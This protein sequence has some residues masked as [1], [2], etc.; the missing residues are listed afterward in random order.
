MFFELGR[1]AC[2]NF[3]QAISHEWLVTNGIGG[4]ACGTVAE[5]NTRRYHGLLMA[6]LSPPTGRVL[7]VSKLDVAACYLKRRYDLFS[8]VFAD[9]T[10]APKGFTLLESFRLDQG[11]PVW[12]YAIADALI[13]KRVVMQPGSNTTLATI[14]ILRAS[15]GIS[16]DL[17]P[18]CAY[19][20]YHGLEQGELAPAIH[21]I[22]GGFEV[23]AFPGAKVYR[24]VCDRG[25][26]IPGFFWYRYFKYRQETQRGLDDTE[27]LFRPG[28]FHLTLAEGEKATVLLTGDVSAAEDYDRVARQIQSKRQH[29]LQALPDDVPEWIEQLALAAEQF[30]VD[31][32]S[33]RD[34]A[35]K[36]VIAG[37][38]WFTDWGRDTMIALPGL[39]L[40]LGHFAIAAD[41][42]RTFAGYVSAGMIPNRFPD[43]G[44]DPEYNTVDAT[45]WFIHALDRYT[46]ESGDAALAAELFPVLVDII[47]W[48]RRGSRYGIRVDS[49]DGLLTAGETGMQLTWMDA[50]VDDWVVTPRSGKCVEINALW[51]NALSVMEGLAAQVGREDLAEDYRHSAQR[52]KS[53]FRRFWNADRQCLYDVIHGE[54]GELHG[55]GRLYDGRLRPNQL[56]AV[57]LPHSPLSEAQQ[58]AVVD[59]CARELLTSYGLRSLA[60]SD[61]GYVLQYQ[62]DRKMRDGAYHQGTVWAWLIG[63]FVD[64]HYRVYRDRE[65]ALSFLEPFRQH[66]NEGC[67]GQIAEI[68]DAIPPFLPRGC[69]AQ[70][71]SVAEVL[72][73]WLTLAR[74]DRT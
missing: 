59:L 40:A 18:L 61:P 70:A 39:T 4:F 54:Q 50:K 67:L 33:G 73:V 29:W 38:P 16:F 53:S 66:L 41:I 12:R 20:D 2:G 8:N 22:Q 23:I 58:R 64:A 49:E 7:L 44:G 32:R 3:E 51:Y 48:H 65:K 35:G 6:A 56:L 47:A 21:Q 34:S 27:D 60:D 31:R 10:I 63:P 62:G 9:G 11:L 36:T 30:I 5:T 55:D 26:Y 17:T 15:A 71:W 52:V 57:S 68:F 45:L 1:A 37:Y 28:M 19:R 69:F 13:E 25:E 42:L 74:Q 46:H 24:V 72:R 14:E 43:Q